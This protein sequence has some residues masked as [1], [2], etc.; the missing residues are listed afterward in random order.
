MARMY[1][2][3]HGGEEQR[4][5]RV[6]VTTTTAWVWLPSASAGHGTG[7]VQRPTN[8]ALG[9]IAFEQVSGIPRPVLGFVGQE[10]S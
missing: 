6:P 2:A 4:D 1:S 7:P 8:T 9:D 10:L 3:A 5:G